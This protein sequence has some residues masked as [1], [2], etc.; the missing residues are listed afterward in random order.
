M[1]KVEGEN[2]KRQLELGMGISEQGRNLVHWKILG[3]YEGD[4]TKTPSKGESGA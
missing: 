4:V 1:G 3:I 2:T